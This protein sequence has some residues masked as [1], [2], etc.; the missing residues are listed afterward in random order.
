MEALPIDEHLPRIADA[1]RER[2][3]LVLV[4]EPGAGKTTRVPP[5]LLDMTPNA[6]V[7]VLEPRRMA[8]RMAAR[9]VAQER[10][11]PLGERIGYRVRFDARAGASTRLCFMTEGVF[12]RRLIDDPELR[13]VQVVVFDE[14]HER[15]LDTDV[16]LAMVQRLRT[17]TRAD[18]RVVAMSATLEASPLAGYLDAASLHVRG[19]NHPVSVSYAP[20]DPRARLEQA[21]AAAVAERLRERSE[22]DTLVFL[23]GVGEISRAARA[24]RSVCDRAGAELATL[25]G[26]LSAAEQDAVVRV[27][28]GPRVILSTNIAES[29]L[30]L[31]AVTTVID[32]GLARISDFSAHTG[33]PQLRVA[34]VSQASANQRAGR[35]GRVREGHCVRLFSESDYRARPE[36]TA[37][38]ILRADLSGLLLWLTARGQDPA[39]FYFFEPPPANRLLA[40]E[41]LLQRLGAL[42]PK[43]DGSPEPLP[44]AELR[45]T[46]RGRRMLTL[47]TH[48]AAGSARARRHRPRRRYPCLRRGSAIGGATGG[49]APN[50]SGAH[51]RTCGRAG[52]AG[53]V[54]AR[55]RGTPTTRRVV[56]A[57]HRPTF[58]G[59]AAQSHSSAE[60]S[61]A[62]R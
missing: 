2:G 22:G 7:L 30:T 29:S 33:L 13:G 60:P 21:V 18:L 31:P 45:L 62:L 48:P 20:P 39:S 23:P 46:E 34:R 17:T 28:K 58:P 14:V 24:C 57:R 11:E 6:E 16:A 50:A 56:G 53:C 19:R 4:A 15:H 12:V 5:M 32:S 41:R 38:E 47:P 36:R 44:S 51:S 8:A 26:R 40:A 35:A 49:G 9:R 43:S 52:A 27:A 59:A 42:S 55:G 37:P 61:R 1:L 10:K 3:A 54:G 25:H